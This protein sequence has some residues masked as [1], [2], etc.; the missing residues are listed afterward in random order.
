MPFPSTSLSSFSLSLSHTHI[1]CRPSFAF[2]SLDL[3]LTIT[4]STEMRELNPRYPHSTVIDLDNDENNQIDLSD[5]PPSYTQISSSP[6]SLPQSPGSPPS[7]L[8]RRPPVRETTPNTVT[9][10]DLFLD[11]SART[12]ISRSQ[13]QQYSRGLPLINGLPRNRQELIV[14][15]VE[16]VP[17]SQGRRYSG[18]ACLPREGRAVVGVQLIVFIIFIIVMSQTVWKRS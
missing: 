11:D 6:S 8:S 10:E 17:I 18:G 5:P 15:G 7:S 9:I 3:D 14:V 12:R 4:M 2:A 1:N 16:P 13:Q